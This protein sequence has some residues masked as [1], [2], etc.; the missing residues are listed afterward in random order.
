MFFFFLLLSFGR[1][2]KGS[3]LTPP[4]FNDKIQV[5]VSITSESR[6]PWPIGV[7]RKKKFVFWRGEEKSFIGGGKKKCNYF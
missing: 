3:K 1:E 6:V 4:V 5:H 2:G 7:N